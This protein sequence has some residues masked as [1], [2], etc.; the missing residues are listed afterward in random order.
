MNKPFKLA[1]KAILLDDHN[2]CLLLR[3]SPVCRNFVGKWEWPGG[4]L[5]DGEDFA[6]ALV[7]EVREEASLEVEITGFGGATSFEMTAVRIVLLCMEAR[8]AQGE[9]RL[10]EEHDEYAWVH[11]TDLAHWD[12]TDQVKPFMLEYANKKGGV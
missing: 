4:K 1:V 12:L 10:S 3:R 8:C 2:R 11:L 7:R 9:V 6:S 5:D